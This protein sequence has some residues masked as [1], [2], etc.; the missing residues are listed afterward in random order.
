MWSPSLSNSNNPCTKLTAK[1]TPRVYTCIPAPSLK[2]LKK[3]STEISSYCYTLC[4]QS[5][6]SSEKKKTQKFFSAFLM[7][8]F[9]FYREHR[10]LIYSCGKQMCLLDKKTTR[11]T[12]QNHQLLSRIKIQPL[13]LKSIRESKMSFYNHKKDWVGSCQEPGDRTGHRSHKFCH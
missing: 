10:K 3:K 2:A 6:I 4:F 7:H 1:H 8:K 9:N 11:N 5:G 13:H 12:I